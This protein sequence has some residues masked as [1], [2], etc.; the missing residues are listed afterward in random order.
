MNQYFGTISFLAQL[1]QLVTQWHYTQSKVQY[2]MNQ[3]IHTRGQALKPILG[4]F[5]PNLGLNEHISGPNVIH[6]GCLQ[7]NV[8]K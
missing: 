1:S 3:S 7:Q 6:Q 4:L 8:L 5:G 2:L